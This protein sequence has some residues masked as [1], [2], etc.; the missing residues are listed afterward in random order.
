MARGFGA[1]LGTSTTDSIA[2]ALT[3]HNTQ[4]SWAVW[5]Y[6]NALG[7][8]SLGR[9]FE[10]RVV[11]G[12]TESL[13]ITDATHY[14]FDRIWSAG[15]PRW[16][17]TAPS[18]SVWSHIGVTYDAGATGNVPVIYLNGASV[19]IANIGSAAS[20]TL[21]TNTDAYVV[22]NRKNDNL[23]NWDGYL[24][25]FA[26]WDALLDAAEM[27][28]LGQGVSPLL[29]RPASLVEYIPMLRD[30]V[31][32]KTAA[33]TIVGT[34]VQPHPRM[35]Y[36]G[37][38]IFQP[39]A[40][41]A[42]GPVVATPGTIALSVTL[43]APRPMI[44][45][46]PAAVAL[47]TTVL[48]PRPMVRPKP[49][50]VSLTT[51]VLDPAIPR[52]VRPGV[53]ALT[54]AL[55][56]PTPIIRP[57]PPAVALTTA[58]LAPRAL[59][60][61]KPASIA[62]AT[63]LLA[64]TPR[65]TLRSVGTVALSLSALAPTPLIRPKPPAIA[66]ST[67]L[68]TPRP[69]VRPHPA[70][71]ALAL[72]ILAP[73]IHT[74]SGVSVTP[75]TIALTIALL[76]PRPLVRVSAPAVALQTALLAP[77]PLVRPKPSLAALSMSMLAPRPR[78]MARPA[79]I[80]LST[81]LLSARA[82]VRPKPSLVALLLTVRT[83]T[84]SVG[85]SPV[86]ATPGTVALVI[87]LLAPRPRIRAHPSVVG[88]VITVLGVGRAHAALALP[89]DRRKVVAIITDRGLAIVLPLDHGRADASPTD[90][91]Y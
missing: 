26:I 47:A 18:A 69:L 31:G 4:R 61:P 12:S 52:T 41:V 39:V 34:A 44:R 6:R 13:Y 64:P 30:N 85:S 37:G 53:I 32:P 35:F 14:E 7:G 15:G 28:A 74:G 11:S 91:S 24:A 70:A 16:Q 20:G 54:T 45:P 66:L 23:R 89:T 84:I 10:K 17:F 60:R 46:M 73:T 72:S 8:G 81:T 33:P 50:A 56:A 87:G 3:A 42:G 55:L 82:L 88:L 43:L 78:L 57:K 40:P 71:V 51:T 80:A 86:V 58:V 22:G 77:R 68:L 63:A 79:T 27:A 83:P 49:A 65:I 21:V 5:T 76:A 25:E 2:S 9:I 36:A 48:D 62:L 38:R 29:I 90:R 67:T 19:S 59:L 75:A 1:T